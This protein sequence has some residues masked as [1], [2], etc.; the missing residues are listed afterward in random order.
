MD[1]GIPLP[2]S[3]SEH[4]ACFKELV[5]LYGNEYQNNRTTLFYILTAVPNIRIH[6]NDCFHIENDLLII[7]EKAL[8]QKWMTKKEAS[9]IRFAFNFY[10]TG[11][12]VARLLFKESYNPK[13]TGFKTSQIFNG[14]AE[15]YEAIAITAFFLWASRSGSKYDKH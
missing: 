12:P 1:M 7:N 5:R 14:L 13:R 4:E 8:N 15:E 6:L 9:L 10:S 11:L 2:F 3:D